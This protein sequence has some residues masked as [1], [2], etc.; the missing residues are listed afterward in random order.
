LS[1]IHVCPLSQIPDTVRASGARSLVTLINEGTPVARPETI[2]ASQHLFVA[3][4]DIV[5]PEDGHILPSE[6]HVA[7]FIAFVRSWDR[8][9]PLV[10]HCYAG[11]SRSTAAAYIAACTLRPDRCEFALARELRARSRTAT[12]NGL[13]VAIADRLLEREGRM[14]AA[15]AEIGRGEDCFE[16]TP[17]VLDLAS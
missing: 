9:A 1:Q 2:E 7:R 5:L 12:P 6:A 11:V 4:S 15:V 10:I 8:Q 17:F 14:I 16:G 13:L 3:L